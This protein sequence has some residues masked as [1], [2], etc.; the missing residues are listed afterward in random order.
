MLSA[1][2][3]K[4][5]CFEASGR[6]NAPSV[7]RTRRTR[8]RGLALSTAAFKARSNGFA[9]R[10]TGTRTIN[11]RSCEAN[12][13]RKRLE[14]VDNQTNSGKKMQDAGDNGESEP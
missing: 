14:R 8:L 2:S 3:S 11:R 5:I 1:F 13:T 12:L 7:P 4:N 9:R 6:Q 10:T